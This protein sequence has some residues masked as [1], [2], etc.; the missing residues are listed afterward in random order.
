MLIIQKKIIEYLNQPSQTQPNL[1]APS[2]STSQMSKV[3]YGPV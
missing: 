1:P 3:V 2:V